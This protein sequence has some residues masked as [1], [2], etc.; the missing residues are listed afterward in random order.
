MIEN[1][2]SDDFDERIMI[3]MMLMMIENC[4]GDDVDDDREL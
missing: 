2:D 3:V 1:S 4:D